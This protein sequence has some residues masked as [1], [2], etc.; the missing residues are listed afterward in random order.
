MSTTPTPTPTQLCTKKNIEAFCSRFVS[1]NMNLSPAS[2]PTIDASLIGEIDDYKDLGFK[3]TNY[4]KTL[5]IPILNP[6][7]WTVA[8]VSVDKS[9]SG[10][11]TNVRLIDTIWLEYSTSFIAAGPAD[12][13]YDNFIGREFFNISGIPMS[14]FDGVPKNILVDRNYLRAYYSKL[15][16]GKLFINND[17]LPEPVLNVTPEEFV[18][19]HSPGL[20]DPMVEFGEYYYMA[21]ELFNFF[22]LVQNTSPIDGVFNDSGSWF[23]VLSSIGSRFGKLFVANSIHGIKYL[24]ID[25][26]YGTKEKL[27]LNGIT[28]PDSATSSSITKDYS[29]G[30]E[31]EYQLIS[32]TP[33][34]YR[35][36]HQDASTNT[37]NNY[38]VN[39]TG[40]FHSGDVRLTRKLEFGHLYN[41]SALAWNIVKH[42]P[43]FT[44]LGAA[45][46]ISQWGDPIDSG[47]SE[48]YDMEH[49]AG[50]S[51]Y[52]NAEYALRNEDFIDLAKQALFASGMT[53]VDF[54]EAVT[55]WE[56]DGRFW[57][58]KRA[59]EYSGGTRG[60][61]QQGDAEDNFFPQTFGFENYG[62]APQPMGSRTWTITGTASLSFVPGQT[63]A[64]EFG[65]TGEGASKSIADL[66]RTDNINEGIILADYGSIPFPSIPM[67]ANLNGV[68]NF[69]DISASTLAKGGT[70]FGGVGAVKYGTL[71]A[72][73]QNLYQNAVNT[74]NKH[75]EKRNGGRARA[76]WSGVRDPYTFYNEN[77]SAL[78]DDNL[79]KNRNSLTEQ[80]Q[81][82]TINEKIAV[83]RREH[84]QKCK[85]HFIDPPDSQAYKLN[86]HKFHKVN[87]LSW[88]EGIAYNQ[89][90]AAKVLWRENNINYIKRPPFS[91]SCGQPGSVP[92]IETI[93]FS[94]VNEL[95]SLTENQMKF[96]EALSITINDG[97]MN[98]KYSFS[99]KSSTPD[100]RGMDAAKVS[101]QNLI[102]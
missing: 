70:Q 76:F 20:P 35:R 13:F 88:Y 93:S 7:N 29:A 56:N 92:F 74:I 6:S 21:Y 89:E 31:T 91:F 98:A 8:S 4:I 69:I 1:L 18:K 59:D 85:S 73:A 38:Y 33:G 2:G 80:E 87:N 75:G 34:R 62:T 97:K 15:N 102:R 77:K 66:V 51:W 5:V 81:V 3:I 57:Y 12:G 72:R 55:A 44:E 46:A 95:Y 28:V 79:R 26:G 39:N 60:I 19:N 40:T 32:R 24:N 68:E 41:V 36:D 65:F 25:S 54:D 99:E 23:D 48:L 58:A 37:T 64:R 10:V 49:L 50:Y 9:S 90:Q 16:S 53:D 14:K 22:P 43:I 61:T 47:V 84:V 78:G 17:G 67:E 100:F 42:H 83:S 11:V 71:Y 94:L 30:Y 101:L 45:Y 86:R 82:E 52:K 63:Q 96:L 27:T